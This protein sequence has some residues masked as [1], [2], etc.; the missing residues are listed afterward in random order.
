[1]LTREE[2]RVPGVERVTEFIPV[3]NEAEIT[4][5]KAILSEISGALQSANTKIRVLTWSLVFAVA[6]LVVMG[7]IVLGKRSKKIE[8]ML[9]I[10]KK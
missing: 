2:L 8:A 6:A 4:G 10:F 5:L 3:T 1:V 7:G 9:G